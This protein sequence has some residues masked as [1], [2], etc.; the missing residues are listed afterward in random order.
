MSNALTL[1]SAAAHALSFGPA[2][3]L[4]FCNKRCYARPQA[5]I[6]QQ[7][8]R[9]MDRRNEALIAKGSAESGPVRAEPIGGWPSQMQIHFEAFQPQHL[10]AQPA[11][12]Q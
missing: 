2:I 12:C 5:Q 7:S 9:C 11:F 4:T 8:Y 1:C 10:G 6:D 3:K